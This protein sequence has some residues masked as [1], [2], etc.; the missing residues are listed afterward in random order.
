MMANRDP[1]S[2]WRRHHGRAAKMTVE[3]ERRQPKK[4]AP[5]QHLLLATAADSLS[6]V[7]GGIESARLNETLT[8]AGDAM[9][10][11]ITALSTFD[12]AGRLV[13]RACVNIADISVGQVLDMDTTLAGRV[14]RA[15][16]PGRVT[17]HRDEGLFLPG[18]AQSYG[19]SMAAPIRS[20]G[21]IIGAISI[22]RLIGEPDYTSDDLAELAA[23]ADFVGVALDV[24]K[25][26][27]SREATLAAEA[28]AKL[29]D[30]LLAT[31]VG[32]LLKAATGIYAVLGRVP[33]SG[34]GIVRL[35]QR[36][37][38]SHRSPPRR[39]RDRAA[40]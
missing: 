2:W 22:G 31:V 39:S 14:I 13:V 17:S 30:E 1:M 20:G 27:Y 16:V 15:G 38:R 35:H 29:A 4:A 37:G 10:G 26:R 9:G 25:A 18:A 8:S 28:R 21:G 23:F 3:F 40:G 5:G 36:R 7:A 24:E 32:D 12:D 6:K 19:P 33:R 11:A 34:C